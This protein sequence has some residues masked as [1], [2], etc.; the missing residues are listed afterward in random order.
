MMKHS[1][2]RRIGRF[3]LFALAG[4]A[5]LAL[6]GWAVMTLWNWLV[7]ALFGWKTITYLQAFAL[8]VLCRLL[9]GGF[10]GRCHRGAWRHRMRERW[11]SMTPEERASFRER[12][13]GCGRVPPPDTAPSA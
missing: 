1:P 2:G 7:P 10:G 11:E 8:I 6:F 12:M 13:H 5:F 3:F 9:F 4:I